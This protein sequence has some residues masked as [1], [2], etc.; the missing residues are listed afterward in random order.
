[1]TTLDY[2]HPN[3]SAIFAE[4]QRRL[5]K[6]REDEE[7]LKKVKVHY[8]HAPWDFITDW[9]MTFE[10]RNMERGLISN[11]PFVLWKRQIEYLH[12]I[13][14]RWKAMEPGLV[15]KSRD[16]GVTWLSVGYA[17]SNWLF[18][19]GYAAGFGSAKEDKVD[20]KGDPDCIF[21]KIRHFINN[22]PDIFMP[23]DFNERDH[24]SFMRLVNPNN[25]STITGDSGDN[26]GRGGRKSMY[27][28]DEKAF[29]EHQEMVDASLS[30]A[31]N[32][33]I[34]ISTPNG[35]GN[36]FYKK[37][38]RY[39]NTNKV[40]IFDWRDDPRKDQTWYDKQVDELD[41]VIVAQEIDRDYTA[42]QEDIFIPAKWVKAAIDAHKKLGFKAVGRRT[43]GF[44][45]ADVGDAKAIIGQHG[46]VIKMG[47]QKRK[48]T[49]AHAL[50]WAFEKADDFRS[51]VFGYDGD[52]MGAP[53]MKVYLDRA[54]SIR[55]KII[56]Y[57]GSA[58]VMDPE[59]H[60]KRKKKVKMRHKEG[61]DNLNQDVVKTNADTYLNFRAQTYS[62]LRDRFETT[63]D[64]IE[65]INEGHI[66]TNLDEDDLI[67]IDSESFDT[68]TLQQLVA[69]L[70]RA[71]RVY[72]N[73]GK[74]QVE[75]KK[76]MRKRQVD[77]PNLSDGAVIANAMQRAKIQD[78]N[79][80]PVTMDPWAPSVK[81]VM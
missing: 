3:Y 80:A 15:E 18:L 62:W 55:I 14:E 40:F 73:T 13:D 39:N 76:D 7:L 32:C 71:M 78:D 79:L 50:P 8:R 69:E 44:D 34:D 9:G 5:T 54:K 45:P 56:A 51:E 16:C 53:S 58:G 61:Q 66:V 59:L 36:G 4:R 65:A 25:G 21:E 28:V 42:S 29:I 60:V 35:S 26:I 12:W 48:G 19:D 81:G 74:I 20:K 43:T 68:D 6:L 31:T 38:Q 46:S 57:H 24:S 49:I 37:R 75:S 2:K 11:I 63:F 77:S 22:L 72:S 30:Q 41:E 17:C 23:E 67:S 1:M 27:F 10:P 52:G 33:Q 64:A 47:A 70:S